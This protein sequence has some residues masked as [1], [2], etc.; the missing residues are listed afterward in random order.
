MGIS[1][2]VHLVA[3]CFTG[4]L[5]YSER[6]VTVR[7]TIEIGY[8]VKKTVKKTVSI[9]AKKKEPVKE[10]A[11]IIP[12]VKE[13]KPVQEVP[14][15]KANTIVSENKVAETSEEAFQGAVVD[16]VFSEWML[17]IRKKLEKLKKY[18][19]KAKEN[20]FE[21]E[22]IIEALI[23]N[24]GNVEKTDIF[25]S[26]GSNSLDNEALRLVKRASPFEMPASLKI[27]KIS[28]RVP[29]KFSLSSE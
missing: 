4:L 10:E 17:S 22:V 24:S 18:P 19:A 1:I 9:S 6:R 3:L 7:N 25:K 21:G 26:S 28:L 29:I 14:E 23:N 2:C 27:K 8:F 12:P 5:S 11:K 20:G 15:T 16:P 13:E